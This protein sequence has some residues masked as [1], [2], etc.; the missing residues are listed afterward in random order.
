MKLTF[1]KKFDNKIVGKRFN[2]QVVLLRLDKIIRNS[3]DVTELKCQKVLLGED[4]RL[5]IG[6][7]V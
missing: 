7:H 1:G 5:C 2:I 6:G 4:K 3:D